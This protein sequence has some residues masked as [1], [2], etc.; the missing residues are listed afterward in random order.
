[1]FTNLIVCVGSFPSMDESYDD[2]TGDYGGP[3]SVKP[4]PYYTRLYC[5]TLHHTTL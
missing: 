3:S 4:R 1:M 5:T 2:R